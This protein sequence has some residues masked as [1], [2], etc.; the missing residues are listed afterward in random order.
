ME[1]KTKILVTKIVVGVVIFLVGVLL[2]KVA[3]M[4]VLKP[5]A[6]AGER[7]FKL[8]NSKTSNL[9]LVGTISEINGRNIVVKSEDETLPILIKDDAKIINLPFALTPEMKGFIMDIDKAPPSQLYYNTISFED[10]KVNDTVNVYLEVNEKG[11][12]QGKGVVRF[13]V[14]YF[15]MTPQ[16][17]E[18]KGQ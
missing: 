7:M 8:I 15:P 11:E 1:E 12:Y 4:K 9:I 13:A 5:K 17:Q 3:T 14:N 10:L 6:E 18:E 16:T 2:G